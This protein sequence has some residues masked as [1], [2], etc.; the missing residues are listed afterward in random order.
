MEGKHVA[1][2]G[3]AR[4]PRRAPETP[5]RP[6]GYRPRRRRSR[7]ASVLRLALRD[8]LLFAL[9]LFTFAFFHH[10]LPR[11]TGSGRETPAPVSLTTPTPPLQTPSTEPD[12]EPGPEAT[13]EPTP[14]PTP[15]PMDW[16]TKFAEQFSETVE[17][18]EDYYRSPDISIRL[19]KVT[20]DDAISTT[21]FIADIYVAHLENFRTAFAG[22]SYRAWAA[23][24]VLS[25]AKRHGAI[26]CMN[27]DYADAQA[28][29][30]L[31]RNGELYLSQ[32]TKNDICVMY[33]DGTVRTYGPNDYKAEDVIAAAPY[34]VWKFGP[35][36][37]DAEGQPLKS[38]N[39]SKEISW[40]NPRSGFGYFEPG[41]YCFILVDGRQNGYSRGLE[42][43]RFA[44]LFADLGCKAAY[45][46]DGGR[47]SVMSFDGA[48][49]NRPYLGGR[50]SGDF[51][52]IC[53][54]PPSEEGTSDAENP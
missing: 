45:N 24:S 22:D 53:E 23:E 33:A 18:G 7:G 43:D 17:S 41:H 34:Q 49:Y 29:G 37:L 2:S 54:L 10:V 4:N 39:T 13:P 14:E 52:M 1:P 28:S 51:L 40:E 12:P 42:I 9:I 8:L 15:D 21:Y 38:F 50:D 47:S 16:K 44:Q 20:N 3:S 48:V 11:L 31:I 6:Q 35:A 36:L 27:G 26:L 5:R 25:A 30:L 32:Q 46:M 19:T